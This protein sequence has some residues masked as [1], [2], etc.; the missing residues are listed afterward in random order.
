[1][2]EREGRER[3]GIV[4]RK[5]GIWIDHRRAVV[6]TIDAGRESRQV[7]ESDLE[8]HAGPEGGRRTSKAYG[9]Q[10][11]DMERQVQDRTQHHL[12]EFYRDVIK[13]IGKPDR[14]LVMGPAEAKR[15]F[16]DL[17]EHDPAL[18]GL[19]MTV[20]AADR[21]TEEQIA[22]KVRTAEF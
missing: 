13:C 3:G 2:I 18:R 12:A 1:M 17:V 15:E 22:V 14:L 6:V 8:R 16:A 7:L 20:E 9:P 21:M 19:I 5:V 4:M 11:K 10:V